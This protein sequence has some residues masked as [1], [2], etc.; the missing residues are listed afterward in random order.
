MKFEWIYCYRCGALLFNAGCVGEL[1]VSG[2]RVYM[3]DGRMVAHKKTG[4]YLCAS[5]LDC[6][7]RVELASFA[8]NEANGHRKR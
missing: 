5:K 1:S 7:K 8:Y 4:R 3:R 2:D 6:G